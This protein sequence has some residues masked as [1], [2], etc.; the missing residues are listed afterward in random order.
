MVT[1][2]AI[3][4]AKHIAGESGGTDPATSESGELQVGDRVWARWKG[5]NFFKG[6]VKTVNDASGG[7]VDGKG[8]TYGIN[9]DDGDVDDAVPAAHVTRNREN[10]AKVGSRGSKVQPSKVDPKALLKA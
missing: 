6:R 5:G 8:L 4:Q 1:W 10:P 2:N 7:G 9:F 3:K